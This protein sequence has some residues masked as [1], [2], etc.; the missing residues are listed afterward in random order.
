MGK[1]TKRD[2][3]KI[4]QIMRKYQLDSSLSKKVHD[5]GDTDVVWRPHQ[6]L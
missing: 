5:K 3:R 4:G 6:L 1:K 2:S